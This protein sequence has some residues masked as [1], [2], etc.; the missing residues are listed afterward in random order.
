MQ[1]QVQMHSI[2]RMHSGSGLIITYVNENH[3]W[4]FYC[5]H[6][7]E[8]LFWL[9]LARN[10][11][12][13]CHNFHVISAFT[14]T[15]WGGAEEMILGRGKKIAR[16]LQ[17]AEFL[18]NWFNVLSHPTIAQPL[19]CWG[20]QSA[21]HSSYIHPEV[22]RTLHVP[23]LWFCLGWVQAQSGAAVKTHRFPIIFSGPLWSGSESREAQLFGCY[24]PLPS[25]QTRVNDH[26]NAS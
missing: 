25:C 8:M 6:W 12:K 3:V 5:A 24:S 18:L 14:R 1:L 15:V 22:S 10:G 21:N 17:I 19:A 9:V 2:V 20:G 26:V 4:I 7:F 13:L 11:T 23:H 16:N